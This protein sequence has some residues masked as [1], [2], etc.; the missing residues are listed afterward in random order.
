MLPSYPGLAPGGTYYLNVRNYLAGS[1]TIT[2]AS[3]GRCD[4]LANINLPH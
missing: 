1:N 3:P 4:A 2:C